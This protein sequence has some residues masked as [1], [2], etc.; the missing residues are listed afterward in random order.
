MRPLHRQKLLGLNSGSVESRGKQ[1]AHWAIL[2]S[3]KIPVKSQRR[4]RYAFSYFMKDRRSAYTHTPLVPGNGCLP[5]TF[6]C[7]LQF[8]LI[9]LQIVDNPASH[10]FVVDLGPQAAGLDDFQFNND[11]SD[12]REHQF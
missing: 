1:R 3:P 4:Q 8:F 9:Y 12:E 2:A 7:Y 5:L 6:F 11:D 10:L